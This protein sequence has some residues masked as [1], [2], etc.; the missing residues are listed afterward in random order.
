[1]STLQ[2]PVPAVSPSVQLQATFDRPIS[3]LESVSFRGTWP[4]TSSLSAIQQSSAK[5][6]RPALTGDCLTVLTS[7]N[8]TDSIRTGGTECGSAE[9]AGTAGELLR[10]KMRAH[11]ATVVGDPAVNPLMELSILQKSAIDV[12]QSQRLWV[13]S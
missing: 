13:F 12:N 6:A 4:G 8:P 2:Q 11:L 10:P 5:L 7:E 1:M 3:A 9:A